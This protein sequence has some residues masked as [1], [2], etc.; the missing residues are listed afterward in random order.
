M[1][2]AKEVTGEYFF[3][4]RLYSGRFTSDQDAWKSRNL[5]QEQDG[6]TPT[7]TGEI[8]LELTY[9]GNGRYEGEIHSAYM[10]THSNAPWSRVGLSGKI[11]PTGTFQGE[12][13]D[14][15]RNQRVRYSQ[16]ELAVE[17]ADLG[18]LRLIPHG[19]EG[20]V[21]SG[22]VVLWPTDFE[23]SGGVAGA[24]FQKLL[25]DLTQADPKSE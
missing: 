24:K 22:E 21:F 9:E 20:D 17:N 5:V 3:N 7:D 25:K 8:Q 23:L 13:W 12:V 19:K 15:V 2:K 1:P 14:I 18:T 4:Y 11:G 16:F 6:K 10:A